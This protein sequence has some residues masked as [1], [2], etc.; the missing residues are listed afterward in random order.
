[1]SIGEALA[2]LQFDFARARNEGLMRGWGDLEAL[3]QGDRLV[4]KRRGPGLVPLVNVQQHHLGGR[5]RFGDSGA[6]ES[7]ADVDALAVEIQNGRGDAEIVRTLDLVQVVQMHLERVQSAMRAL[8]VG[9]VESQDVHHIVDGE[10]G[11]QPVVGI[12]QMPVVV[13][14]FGLDLAA[15]NRQF[16]HRNSAQRSCS[17]SRACAGVKT[18]APMASMMV[19]AFSTNCALLAYTPLLRYRLSSSPTRTLPP[20]STACATHG[21]CMRLIAKVPQL[22]FSGRVLTMAS[23]WPTSAGTP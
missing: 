3:E 22:Q 18:L 11:Y 6:H 7:A 17:F 23:R 21:I 9:R 19:R 20:S 4:R 2:T 13:D 10:A 8:A 5:D 1:M 16:R 15:I 14:P 12:A